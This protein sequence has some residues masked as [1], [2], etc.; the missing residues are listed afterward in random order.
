[1]AYS[2]AR[3]EALHAS[4]HEDEARAA[5]AEAAQRLRERALKIHD[6]GI[7]DTFLTRVPE[8][9]RTLALADVWA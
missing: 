3:A 9:A 8:D 2:P 4:G 7:R 5:I 1:M 6:E